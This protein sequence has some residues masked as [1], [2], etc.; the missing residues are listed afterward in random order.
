M[1]IL[2]GTVLSA[3]LLA[4]TPAFADRGNDRGFDRHGHRFHKQQRYVV[5]HVYHAPPRYVV[6]HHVYRPAPAY[7]AYAPAAGIHVVLPNIFIP[8]N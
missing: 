8:L 4:A 1:K 7:Y 5:R 2:T 3:V 6:Q